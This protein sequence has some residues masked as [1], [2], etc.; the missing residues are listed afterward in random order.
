MPVFRPI[1]ASLL[2]SLSALLSM[3]ATAAAV[4]KPSPARKRPA[5]A[6]VAAPAQN[7]EAPAQETD[8]NKTLAQM[9]ATAPQVTYTNGSLQIVAH[10]STLGDILRAVRA[11]T[12]AT[13]DMPQDAT[14][15][16]V[17]SLGPAPAR[18][19]LATLLNGSSFN[20]VMVG[21]PVDPGSVQHVVLTVKPQGPAPGPAQANNVPVTNQP[22]A[23]AATD[24]S[25]DD[26]G[27][28]ENQPEEPDQQVPIPGQ[29]QPQAQDQPQEGEQPA[30][31]T[32]EQLLQELQH[33]QQEQLQ[34]QQD[35]PGAPEENS[36][37][38]QPQPLLNRGPSPFDNQSPGSEPSGSRPP[39]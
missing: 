11:K 14:E 10:N 26:S 34:K 3:P 29:E 28:A 13:I 21:S 2:L 23:N 22:D 20:Y 7:Q 19:V 16:V 4:R 8:E 25:S 31:K 6:A 32:P 5:Q 36:N 17:V 9:P 35:Q 30:I 38:G 18:Q 24:E 33:Q 37:P 12:G 15:R 1:F 39:Q 27:D